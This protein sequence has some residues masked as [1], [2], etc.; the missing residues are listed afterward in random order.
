MISKKDLDLLARDLDGGL[1]PAE[2]RHVDALLG[3]SGEAR[4][5]KRAMLETRRHVEASAPA[6]DGFDDS[7]VEDTVARLRYEDARGGR[8]IGARTDRLTLAG[9]IRYAVAAS[10]AVLAIALAIVI[11][12]GRTAGPE[13]LPVRIV[14]LA[15]GSRVSLAVGASL[16][17][18]D[19]FPDERRVRLNGEA[20]FEVEST[21]YPFVVEVKQA[22][23]VVTGTSFNVRAWD[24][25]PGRAEVALVEGSVEVHGESDPP[26]RLAPGQVFRLGDTASRSPGA[27]DLNHVVAWRSSGFGFQHETLDVVFAEV[28]RRYATEITLSSDVDVARRLTYLSQRPGSLAGVL[29]D[30][31]HAVNLRFSPTR[32]G[33]EIHAP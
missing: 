28:A 21:G 30:L 5:E 4:D 25:G 22:E 9:P 20:F 32:S 26:V 12:V 24:E 16:D 15:D 19:E 18:P 8:E 3:V 23:I 1:T 33:Y 29:S 11:I 7:F 27:A 10:V 2:Q 17:L 6:V 14:D 31:C 13:Q